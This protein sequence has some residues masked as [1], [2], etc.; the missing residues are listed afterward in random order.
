MP[1]GQAAVDSGGNVKE[2][3]KPETKIESLIRWFM[4]SPIYAG[5][6]RYRVYYRDAEMGPIYPEITAYGISLACLLYK[7]YR[8]ERLLQRAKDCAG[9]LAG[10]TPEGGLPSYDT[11]FL[12]T[13]D[14]GMFISGL[15]DLYE[16]TREEIYL[17]AAKKNVDW[18]LKL[19]DGEKFRAIDGKGDD[20]R[21]AES[22]SAHLVKLA[23]PLTKA[24]VVA[25][26]N[27]C[28]ET[29][30]RLLDWGRRLQKGPGNFVIN[31]KLNRTRTHPHCY[32][33]EGFLFAYHHLRMPEY[34]EAVKKAVDWLASVQNRDG[35]FYE[36][37]P[38]GNRLTGRRVTDATAQAVRLWKILGENPVNESR[39][40]EFLERNLT[41][42]GGLPL[43]RKRF[44][45]RISTNPEVYSW[46]VFFYLHNLILSE[47][48][49]E[50]A[51]EI[52]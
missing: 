12:Y 13:F 36:W 34:L 49:M 15:F 45:R 10:I 28:K 31:E 37:Y 11:P 22:E 32:A 47:G 46:P 26:E 5:E 48:G 23:I 51:K 30:L 21:W 38:G 9:Y 25:G 41:A 8:Q 39:G 14:T 7:K 50:N 52:F 16:I 43:A 35:S 27:Q 1:G 40:K 24:Y 6:G 18:L 20:S 19:F 17:S 3:A 4:E 29:C 42:E 2:Q 33:A 44:S